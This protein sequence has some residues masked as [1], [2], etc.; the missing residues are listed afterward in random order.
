[1]ACGPGLWPPLA[2]TAEPAAD[3][4]PPPRTAQ[5]CARGCHPPRSSDPGRGAAQHVAQQ[6]P[7]LSSTSITR[8]R[9]DSEPIVSMYASPLPPPITKRSSAN[10]SSTRRCSGR[11]SDSS[12]HSAASRSARLARP[13]SSEPSSSALQGEQ[14]VGQSLGVELPVAAHL[15]AREAPG[16]GAAGARLREQVDQLA[17]LG[18]LLPREEPRLAA[19]VAGAAELQRLPGAVVEPRPR[20][21][22]E[23]HGARLEQPERR[24]HAAEADARL[25]DGQRHVGADVALEHH[26]HVRLARSLA[27]V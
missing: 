23:R 16:H 4:S 15:E 6:R 18:L 19:Q 14:V 9:G 7:Q 25:G 24:Q 1:M 3:P 17:Q 20:E 11:R 21:R 12:A 26:E 5:R 22:A 27:R 2:R 8:S 10:A 13:V